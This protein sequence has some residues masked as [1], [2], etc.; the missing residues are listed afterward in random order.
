MTVPAQTPVSTHVGNGVTTSFAYGFKLLDAA[1]IRVS[2]A[3]VLKTLNTDYTVT[4]IGAEAGGTIVFLAAPVSLAAIELVRSVTVQRLTDYQYSGDFQSPTVNRDF[5]R[6]VMMLQDSGVAVANALRYPPG[7][8]ASGVLPDAAARALKGLAFDADGNPFLTTAAGDAN[9]LAAQLA[10]VATS[11]LGGG[12]VGYDAA[13]AYAGGTA[14]KGIKDAAA[15]AAAGL[16]NAATALAA[17]GAATTNINAFKTDV[18]SVADNAKG[19]ALMG[20]KAPFTGAVGRT[21]AAKLA[22]EA[23]SVLDF[24]ADP[25]GAADATAAFQAAYAASKV[26]RV[27]A[28]I[29][30]ITGAIGSLTDGLGVNW[31]GDGSKVT[32]IRMAHASA[33]FQVSGRGWTVAEIGFEAQAVVSAAIKCGEVD[34]NDN[35]QL[36]NCH[37]ISNSPVSDG[38]GQKYFLICCDLY[39]MWY[40]TITGNVFRN[41]FYNDRFAGVGLKFHYSVNNT[42]S[43][44]SFACFDK[45]YEW[46]TDTYIGTYQCEGH[47]ISGNAFVWNTWHIYLG[48]GLLACIVGNILDQ[49]PITAYPIESYATCTQLVGNWIGSGYP[50]FLKNS[51]RHIV[52]NNVFDQLVGATAAGHAALVIDNADYGIITGNVVRGYWV[53]MSANS[54]CSFWTMT[55]NMAVGQSSGV[56]WNF[57]LMNAD[58]IFANNN[59][60]DQIQVFG[61]GLDRTTYATTVVPTFGSPGTTQTFDIPLPVNRFSVPPIAMVTPDSTGDLVCSVDHANTT[62]SNVRVVVKKRDGTSFSGGY[63]FFLNAHAL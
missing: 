31:I 37:F 5:D 27:P 60:C 17:A 50:V 29:Y 32:T 3:G 62:V 10:S 41:G 35:A 26:I 22:A 20:Y 63:R 2:V 8:P 43:E 49:A 7:D 39:R 36:T 21:L 9:A 33:Q 19:A 14:G 38:A 13:L 46:T 42:I 45:A 40:S 54:S 4:G 48:A 44:N 15:A 61:T 59:A 6:L 23:V 55:G 24:G 18:A 47:M 30:T 57:S 53:G 25:T 12:Q 51:D 1:D 16:A 11:A 58:S 52:A 56:A 34:S 28:G